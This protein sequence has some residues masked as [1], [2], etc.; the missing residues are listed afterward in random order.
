M[1]VLVPGD[2]IVVA[3]VDVVVFMFVVVFVVLPAAGDGFTI[4]VLCSVA[5]DA[6]V[7]VV[8]WTSV[9]CSQ[10]P[11]RAALARM[12]IIFFIYIR[13]GC[14]LRDKLESRGLPLLALPN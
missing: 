7:P 1:S 14:P 3:G 11:R 2:D 9:R 10:A 6:A 8:G 13:L 5:G 12:Q 4:V